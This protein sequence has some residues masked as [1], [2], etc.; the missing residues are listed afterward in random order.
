MSHRQESL[1]D[2]LN[3][4]HLGQW[5][6]SRRRVAAQV[7]YGAQGP[8]LTAD[9]QRPGEGIDGPL[10]A[11]RI[12]GGQVDQVD[13]VNEDGAHARLGGLPLESLALLH[14]VVLLA[15]GLGRRSK[16]L[17]R[18]GAQG[19]GLLDSL[20]QAS[21]RG[22]VRT[23]P[24]RAPLSGGPGRARDR[25]GQPALVAMAA[26]PPSTPQPPPGPAS[27]HELGR[28]NDALPAFRSTSPF[29][30]PGNDSGAAC[31]RQR[32]RCRGPR[33]AE[34]CRHFR[35]GQARLYPGPREHEQPM[36]QNPHPQPLDQMLTKRLDRL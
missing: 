31:T 25:P 34:L 17:D 2:A 7:E 15:P 19:L 30:T 14:R 20:S 6:R 9:V 16:D 21:L 26:T 22:H 33:P 5:P 32:R 27:Q 12:A 23:N 4:G 3:G 11:R 10:Q 13:A 35:Q 28:V 24:H 8:D 36:E 18:L 29:C 1:E